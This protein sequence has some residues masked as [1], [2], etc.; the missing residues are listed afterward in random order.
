ML[1]VGMAHRRVVKVTGSVLKR[2]ASSACS[3]QAGQTFPL[4]SRPQ[5]ARSISTPGPGPSL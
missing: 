2:K 5:D 1:A 4:S 3:Q